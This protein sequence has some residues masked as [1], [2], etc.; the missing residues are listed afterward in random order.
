MIRLKSLPKSWR[1]KVTEAPGTQKTKNTCRDKG[2][3]PK[4]LLPRNLS[5]EAILELTEHR[6]YRIKEIL[7]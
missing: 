5:F 4:T 1:E 3:T 7:S 2:A 6:T